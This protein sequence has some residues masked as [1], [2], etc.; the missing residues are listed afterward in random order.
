MDLATFEA[1]NFRDTIEL[2]T[3]GIAVDEANRRCGGLELRAAR[4]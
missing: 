1:A 3:E 2:N 4:P